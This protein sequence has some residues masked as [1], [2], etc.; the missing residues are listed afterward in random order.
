M[1]DAARSP[2]EQAAEET[3]LAIEACIDAGKS[4]LV[5]AGAGAGKTYSLI[6]ALKYVIAK[7]GRDFLRQHQRVACITYTNVAVEEINA[8]TDR[9]PAV[10]SS[11]IHSFCWSMIRDFQPYLRRELPNLGGWADKLEEVGGL[12]TQMITY[13]ELGHR[14]IDDTHAA[15]HHND[16]LTLAV[17]LLGEPKF[18]SIL[19]SRHPILFIDEYQD[20][21]KAIA[22]ALMANIL[23][24]GEGPLIGFFG[25]HW[26]KI[27]GNGCGK[28]DHPSLKTIGKEANF[29][30][31]SAV[32]NCLNRIRPELPQQVRDPSAVGSVAVYHTNSWV[33]KRLTGQH[34]GGDLPADVAGHYLNALVSH[35]SSEGWDLPAQKTKILML[36]HK[37]LATKQGY[38][39]LADVFPYNDAFIKKEDPYI[40]FFVDEL[41]PVCTAYEGKRFGEMFAAMGRRTPPI[42][43]LTDKVAW[44]RDMDKLLELR[45]TGTVGEILDHLK[46]TGRPRL[47]D[48]VERRE[49][50]LERHLQE[51]GE[52]EPSSVE[53]IRKLREVSYQEVVRL[54]EF[55]DEKTPFSTKH[56]VKGAEFE[57]VL[58]VFGRGWNLYN[59]S[60]FLEWGHA[61]PADKRKAWERNRNLF[62]VTCSRPRKRLALMFTQ[63]LSDRAIGTLTEW[64]GTEAIKSLRINSQTASS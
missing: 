15:L 60:Q 23:D 9:H 62:Y 52:E 16:V 44:A 25:D 53:R 63:K 55:I 32:V 49:K 30:S 34:W 29:R 56:G 12:G 59:F 31:V 13:D 24:T 19:A 22:E 21:D 37:V 3:R 45:Q 28:I 11:T 7:R 38:G 5:E 8:R 54:S 27:Y 48:A 14:T 35:L 1:P 33:G 10:Q 61:P 17:K 57:N 46:Q 26:Q 18:R 36:T 47:S 2:A 42:L 51:T 39:G 64:F 50:A 41:E 4:F 58:V 40:C 20:T 43:S 6:E